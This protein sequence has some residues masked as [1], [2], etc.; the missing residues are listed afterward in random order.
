MLTVR[1]YPTSSRRIP[2]SYE[3]RNHGTMA[4]PLKARTLLSLSGIRQTGATI[5]VELIAHK[6]I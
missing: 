2:L 6:R 5:G 4:D 3:T 1:N